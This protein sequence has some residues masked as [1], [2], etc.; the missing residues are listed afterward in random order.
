MKTT[1]QVIRPA[2]VLEVD[3]DGS[4]MQAAIMV[5]RHYPDA[6][7]AWMCWDGKR[8]KLVWK[9]KTAIFAGAR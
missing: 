7:E 9:A 3:F 5:V 8:T 1:V 2:G 4:A 6:V